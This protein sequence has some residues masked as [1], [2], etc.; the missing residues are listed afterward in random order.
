[1]S[2]TSGVISTW[3][4]SRRAMASRGNFV[5]IY[6]FAHHAQ[7]ICAARCGQPAF[8][9]VRPDH[10]PGSRFRA[11]Q[12]DIAWSGDEPRPPLVDSPSMHRLR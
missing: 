3:V 2:S 11:R 5:K 10:I 12:N 1:L 9:R 8:C 6:L 4:E 7:G